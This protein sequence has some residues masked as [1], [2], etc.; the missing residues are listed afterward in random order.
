MM[1][2]EH[3][4]L[5]EFTRSQTADRKGIDNTPDE[6]AIERMRRLCKITME[7]IREHF[8]PVVITSG[9]RCPALNAA[10]GG[11]DN[12][13]HTRGEAAD[14]EAMN[15]D[16]L[17]VAHWCAEHKSLL[18]FDQLILEYHVRGDPH[19]GWV[20]ISYG[21]RIRREILTAIKGEGYARGLVV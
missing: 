6:M 10:I 18:A 4:A 2:S 13:S 3:F 20:H 16:N 7:P 12:S 11:A 14:F 17:Y 15:H 21:P 8:G 5:R 19:S 1:L 9:F